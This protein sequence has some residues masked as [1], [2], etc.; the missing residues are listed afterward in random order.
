MNKEKREKQK[1]QTLKYR[2]GT[3]VCQRSSGL[4]DWWGK[5]E[6]E[7][8]VKT[9]F[10]TIQFWK[11]FSFLCTLVNSVFFMIQQCTFLSI[12]G[13]LS[14]GPETYNIILKFYT[15]LIIFKCIV[16]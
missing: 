12:D 10:S 13:F 7:I 14:K 1:T 11:S 16:Q 15:I 2:E 4:G 5:K 8:L 6:Q 3:S 9:F